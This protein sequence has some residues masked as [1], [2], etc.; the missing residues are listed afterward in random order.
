MIEIKNLKK[1]DSLEGIALLVEKRSDGLAKNGKPF[2]SLV[3]RDKTGSIVGK[4]WDNQSGLFPLFR[5]NCVVTVWG[6]VEEYNGSLQLKIGEAQESLEDP[7]SFSKQTEFNV[8]EMF[9]KLT[10]IIGSMKEPLTRFVCEEIL[11]R[12][13]AVTE[14]FKKAP[15]AKGMHNAWYGGLLEHV[16]S[17]C[18]IAEPIIRHYQTRYCKD[19]SRDKV[20]FGLMMHDAGKI[21]EYDYT[22]PAFNYTPI[23]QLTNHMVLGPAWVYEA[24]NKF[25]EKN[26]LPDF[27]M[28]RAHLMHILAAHHGSNEW[29]SPVVPASLEAI[30]VH[31]LDNLDAKMLHALDFVKGKQGPVPGFSERSYFERVHYLQYT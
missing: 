3:L 23:G 24:A 9:G 11:L 22:K 4:L 8:E 14:A 13:V 18:T 20:M 25:P 19:L 16:H 6:S 1:F 21:V 29:G 12:Q 28:Q 7:D 15:A 2:V 27:K 10:E 26:A 5:E 17:L 30:M 31:H